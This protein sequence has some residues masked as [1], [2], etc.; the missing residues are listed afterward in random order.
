M[1]PK[2]LLR[3]YWLT[4][5]F[6][7]RFMDM[8]IVFV[9]GWLAYAIKVEGTIESATLYY[10]YTIAIFMGTLLVPIVFLFF[11]IYTSIRGK[12]FLSHL[13]K[14]LQATAVLVLLLAGLAFF[15]KTGQI[16]SRLWFGSWI[17][18]SF[19]LLI[20]FRCMILVLLRL[21]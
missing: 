6:L 10:F 17:A 13:I 5:S 11:H 3:E 14:L 15:T 1:L 18:I 8:T 19:V 20:F 4:L 12:D 9:A 16:Y 7:M 2:G 21:M